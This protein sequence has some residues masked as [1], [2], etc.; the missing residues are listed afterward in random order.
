MIVK[1]KDFFFLFI[2]NVLFSSGEYVLML[3]KDGVV[4]AEYRIYANDTV[5]K[6]CLKVRNDEASY[7]EY[8]RLSGEPAPTQDMLQ[9]FEEHLKS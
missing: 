4:E 9:W 7:I 6:F 1:N 5:V 2:K 3:E 8:S